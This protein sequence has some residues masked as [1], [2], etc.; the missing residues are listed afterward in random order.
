MSMISGVYGGVDTHADVHVAV[1]IDANSA[2]LGVES[3]STDPAGYRQLTRWLLGF[4][5]VVCVGVEGTGSYGVGLARHLRGEGI[6]VVE[7][8]RPSRQTRHRQ[9][10]SDS[11]DAEV[12]ARA[13]L[14]GTASVV[15]KRRDGAV[16]QMRVL[17]VARR[18][19]KTQRSQTLNQLRQV[20]MCG[21]DQV[22]ARFK[23]RP[24]D[25]LITEAAGMRPRKGSDPVVY[26]TNIVIRGLAGRIQDLDDEKKMI[27]DALCVLIVETAPSLLKLHGV[28][29]VTAG[30]LLV[31]AGDNPERLSSERSW[32]KLCGVAPI[33][34]GSGRTDGRV[35]LNRGG[36]RQANSV[37][38]QIVIVRMSS[39]ARTRNYVKR[40]R[41]EGLSKREIIRCLKRYVARE[42]FKHLPHAT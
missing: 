2:V 24:Q 29:V 18:S 12:A 32:A 34:T 26:T 22:R 30:T 36:N 7:V 37:L 15:P 27:D 19:A 31:A 6:V 14:S 11:I 38:Y 33:P 17:M 42:T 20:V 35:R 16:E 25:G 13:A 4:G 9:G 1:A 40:R 3:F 10:K 28:G 5:P 41:V 21:P 39:D 8:D 23:D